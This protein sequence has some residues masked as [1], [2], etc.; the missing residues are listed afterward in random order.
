MTTPSPKTV[1]AHL[2]T[3]GVNYVLESGYSSP[4]IDPYDGGSRFEGIVVH[5][6]AGRDSLALCLRGTYP[7]VRN[8]HFLVDRTGLVHV[9][10]LI[11]AYHAGEGGPW[12]FTRPT[13]RYTVP[14]DMGNQHLYG[15]EIESLGISGKIDG[16]PEGMTI[17]QVIAVGKL[18]AALLDSMDRLSVDRVIRHRD[19]T[20]RK[21]VDP[22]QTLPFWRKVSQLAIDNKGKRI[23]TGY[24]IKAYVATTP[25]AT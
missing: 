23:K 3:W 7:P 22:R 24:A 9:C 12:T 25:Y 17:G 11:G 15:I 20:P 5:H 2:D 13:P 8:C 14:K 4:R 16:S 1:I 21:P 6:T 10:S 19:W 18:N